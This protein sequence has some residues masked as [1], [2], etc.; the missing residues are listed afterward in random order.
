VDNNNN[1]TCIAQIRQGRKC[2]Y[3]DQTGAWIKS[4][5]HLVPRLTSPRRYCG[6]WGPSSTL[7]KRGQS[8][9]PNFRPM[10]I[11]A[12]GLD[13]SRLAFVTEVG[14]GPGHIVLDG[15]LAPLPIKGGRGTPP[16]F[17]LFLLW[18]IAWMHQDATWYGGRPRPRRLC[19]RWGGTQLPLEIWAHPPHAI[20]GP[21][22]LWPNGWMDEDATWYG[23]RPWPR[24]RCIRRGPS[25]PAKGTQQPPPLFGP[26]LLWT[27]S[28]I[29]AADELLMLALMLATHRYETLEIL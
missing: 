26:C 17:G 21:C 8:P 27:R 29:S 12:K 19:V 25:F 1:V 4:R 18:P 14:L 22:L 6:R 7:P 3:C 13:G 11:V 15:N 20:F 5:C 10:S 23:S 16:I 2:R 9:L 24:P 28:P